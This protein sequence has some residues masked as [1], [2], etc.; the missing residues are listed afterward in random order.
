MSDHP[1]SSHATPGF[2]AALRYARLYIRRMMQAVEAHVLES[3]QRLRS[4]ASTCL[5]VSNACSEQACRV[6]ALTLQHTGSALCNNAENTTPSEPRPISA[7]MRIAEMGS[8]CSP[9][10]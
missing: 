7:P 6:A 1:C 8:T 10:D 9:M 2:V 5:V 3:M 4:A